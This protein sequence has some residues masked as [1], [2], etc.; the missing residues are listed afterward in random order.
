[1]NRNYAGQYYDGTPVTGAA[2]TGYHFTL[3]S[4]DYTTNN[5]WFRMT[6]GSN[7]EIQAK[8]ALSINPGGSLN[9]YTCKPGQNL[10]G[11]AVFPWDSRAGGAQD[12]VVLHYG[13]LPNGYISP[14]NLG[15]TAP[16]E[17][18]HYL[19]LYHTFQG[20]CTG[21]DTA[22]GCST[23]GN[24]DEVCDTAAQATSTSGCP[25][26]KDTCP[27]DGPDP[28]HNYMDY[29]I[30]ACYNNFTAGQDT[31]MNTKVQAYPS[32][33]WIG[34]TRLANSAGSLQGGRGSEA[35]AFGLRAIP[36][37]FNPR[38]KIE[39]SMQREGHALVR[40]YD[41]QGRTVATIVNGRLAQGAHRY[42]FDGDRLASGIYLMQLRVDG[43]A[44]DVRRITL[45][46]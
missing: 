2:N 28:I 30:D 29:S 31:R 18:G 16:H 38:T 44:V 27:S 10:L 25:E 23:P 14:Y 46:R 43:R 22:P 15:G 8:N 36:N 45:M 19:G 6:P 37:P 35:V 26:G 42:D 11:W 7:A 24:G 34:A 12:G 20:G 9:I 39:F 40:V 32:R 33:S 3:L 41:I 5:K 21:G 4:T 13:S 17:V 1:M